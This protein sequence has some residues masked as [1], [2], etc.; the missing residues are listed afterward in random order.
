MEKIKRSGETLDIIQKSPTPLPA[1]VCAHLLPKQKVPISFTEVAGSP[2]VCGLLGNNCI[3]DTHPI[4]IS[5][6]RK[7]ES[8]K[9]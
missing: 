1:N 2:I 4:Q 9:A 3:L 8:Y 5:S 7:K 6:K